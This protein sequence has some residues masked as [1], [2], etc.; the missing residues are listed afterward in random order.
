MK[1]EDQ[2][3]HEVDVQC[4]SKG[5]AHKRYEVGQ[6][7]SAATTNRGNWFVGARLCKSN[8]Y[9]GHTLAAALAQVQSHTRHTVNGCV[10]GQGVPRSRLRR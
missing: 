9:D 10:R 3:M 4:I 6:K 8:P 5:K 1:P 2:P 7:V